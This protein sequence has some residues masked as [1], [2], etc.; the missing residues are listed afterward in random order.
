ML[1]KWYADDRDL[2]KWASLVHLAQS[3][4]IHTILQVA[5]YRPAPAQPVVLHVDGSEVP[6]PTEILAHFR[7]L[8]DVRRL[9]SRTGLRIDIFKEP[10]CGVEGFPS[11]AAAVR[12]R[13]FSLLTARIREYGP[14]RLIAFLDPDTGIEPRRADWRH[15]TTSEIGSVYETLK[16]GDFLVLYQHARRRSGWLAT[17]RAQFADAIGP[18]HARPRTLRAPDLAQDVALFAVEKHVT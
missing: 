11:R 9:A 14:A 15:V 7:D 5:F 2:V 3:H 12:K 6:F 1:D 8:D 16:P 18:Q 10:F 13:Y 17:T 4:G